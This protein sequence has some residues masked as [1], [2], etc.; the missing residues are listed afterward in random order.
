MVRGEIPTVIRSCLCRIIR[1]QRYLFG[2]VLLDELKKLLCRI[3]FD[4][5][6]GIWKFII[7]QSPQVRQIGKTRMS[8][9]GTRVHG[10]PVSGRARA[11]AVMDGSWIEYV[12]ELDGYTGRLQE[13]WDT[14]LAAVNAELQRLGLDPVD[15]SDESIV[16]EPPR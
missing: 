13:V 14:D 9:I 8:L 3:A 1:N 2:L 4:I 16:L 7:N 10:Q 5:E 6:L 11:S 12:E 15:P